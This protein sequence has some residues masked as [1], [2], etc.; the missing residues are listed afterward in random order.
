MRTPVSLALALSLAVTGCGTMLNLSDTGGKGPVPQNTM[1]GGIAQDVMWGSNE[2]I[3]AVDT[4]VNPGLSTWYDPVFG[5]VF[6]GLCLA[7]LPVSAVADTLTLPITIK[8]QLSMPETTQSS[9]TSLSMPSA[10]ELR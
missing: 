3:C 4:R 6:A 1:C 8:A 2:F 7:D 9:A 5:V 10:I